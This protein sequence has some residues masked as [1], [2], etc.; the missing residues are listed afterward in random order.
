MVKE[1]IITSQNKEIDRSKNL[2]K[3]HRNFENLFGKKF[4]LDQFQLSLGASNHF[5]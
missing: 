3:R 2:N 5:C 1:P 4:S